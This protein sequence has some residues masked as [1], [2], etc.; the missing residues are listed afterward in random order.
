M[1]ISYDLFFIFLLLRVAGGPPGG[2]GPLGFS[3][4]S[5]HYNPALATAHNLADDKKFPVKALSEMKESSVNSLE[6]VEYD[7]QN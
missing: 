3:P 7:N 4:N 5:P 2:G 1:N 6:E